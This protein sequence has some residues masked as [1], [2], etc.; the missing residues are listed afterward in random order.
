[1]AGMGWLILRRCCGWQTNG[2]AKQNRRTERLRMCEIELTGLDGSNLLAYLAA[3]GTLRVLTLA[4]P[5]RCVRMSWTDRGYWTPLVQGTS[6]DT[7]KTLVEIL[8]R[9][10]CPRA[11]VMERKK[12]KATLIPGSDQEA[13]LAN[14]NPAFLK[15]YL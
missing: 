13:A 2:R 11:A 6:A 5:E 1:M 10:V 8:G 15:D 4:E 3:L 7:T 9:R 14:A 12:E